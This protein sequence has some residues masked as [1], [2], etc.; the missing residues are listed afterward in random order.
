M[1]EDRKIIR[2][3][4]K[5]I[6]QKLECVV[7]PLCFDPQRP[8][9]QIAFIDYHEANEFCH[10]TS[11]ELK[12]LILYLPQNSNIGKEDIENNASYW[13]R[14]RPIVKDQ[15]L[16][17]E[18]HI[19]NFRVVNDG[20]IYLIDPKGKSTKELMALKGSKELISERNYWWDEMDEFTFK[21]K[22]HGNGD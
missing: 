15:S 17:I 4:M 20:V 1:K 16:K 6:D 3:Y 11:Y 2:N 19:I 8:S 9:E 5:K 10:E 22:V 14:H 13:R 7:I 12:E 21:L 18:D